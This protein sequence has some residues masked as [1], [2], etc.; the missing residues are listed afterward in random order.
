MEDYKLNIV[1]SN[2]TSADNL[3]IPLPPFTLIGATTRPGDL[4][5][6]LRA[7]F[8][9]SE[10]IDFYNDEDLK[11]I[12]KRTAKYFDCFIDEESAYEIG[13]RSRGTPRIANRIFK[14]VRDFVQY[15]DKNEITIKTTKEALDALQ[16]DNIGLDL[17][18]QNYLL[19][20][21]NRFNGGP[22]G[23]NTIANAIGE[24]PNNLEEVC[25]PFLIQIG[26]IDKTAKGRIL[27]KKALNH[28]NLSY[29]K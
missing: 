11:I 18:D 2:E 27:T 17:I 19:T 12:V 4:S 1:V 28:L 16:I 21:K 20:L 26:L 29:K 9:I 15:E 22:V 8:G 14:R 7:R 6:P 25:E 10:K 5:A 24:V 13:H 3:N 23:L